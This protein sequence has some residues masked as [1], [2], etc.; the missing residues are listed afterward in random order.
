MECLSGVRV[1]A[2]YF[3]EDPNGC[4]IDGTVPNLTT[5]QKKKKMNKNFK[6][7]LPHKFD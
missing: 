6:R 4:R 1:N 3:F 2:G 7:L 5:K